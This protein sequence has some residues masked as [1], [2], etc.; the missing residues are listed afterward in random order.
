MNPYGY[1]DRPNTQVKD[2]VDLVLL[3][4]PGLLTDPARLHERVRVV[5]DVR[6]THAPPLGLPNPPAT[7]EEFPELTSNLQVGARTVAEAIALLR[8]F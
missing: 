3:V 4:E 5:F 7:W 2:L 6:D 1:G 8:P